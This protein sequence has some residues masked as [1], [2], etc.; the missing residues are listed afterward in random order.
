[1]YVCMYVCMYVH[2]YV[3]MG[4]PFQDLGWVGRS[5]GAKDSLYKVSYK[6]KYGSKA[7]DQESSGDEINSKVILGGWTVVGGVIWLHLR[8]SRAKWKHFMIDKTRQVCYRKPYYPLTN[9]HILY[10][11]Q[12]TQVC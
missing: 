1:M 2:M 10:D 6:S 5:V 12:N 9:G 7:L 3:Y 4:P 11:Q 8:I